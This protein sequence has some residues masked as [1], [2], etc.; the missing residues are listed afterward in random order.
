MKGRGIEHIFSTSRTSLVREDR[1][2]SIRL[3][4]SH[5]GAYWDAPVSMRPC[6]LDVS[7][8]LAGDGSSE[9]EVEL[10]F[11]TT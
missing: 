10:N 3:N 5:S 4:R 1:F 2:Q 9:A 8:R 11:E 7:H 6:K